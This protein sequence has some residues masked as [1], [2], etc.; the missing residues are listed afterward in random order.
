MGV[1]APEGK[2]RKP[3]NCAGRKPALFVDLAHEE[4]FVTE[5]PLHN[6]GCHN[7]EKYCCCCR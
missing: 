6:G 7:S 2:K 3:R 5:D 1:G 4:V